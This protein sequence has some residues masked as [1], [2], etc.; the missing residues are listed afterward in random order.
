[1]VC[2]G[3][4]EWA[5]RRLRWRLPNVLRAIFGDKSSSKRDAAPERLAAGS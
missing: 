1:L 5:R 2:G 3:F 4:L